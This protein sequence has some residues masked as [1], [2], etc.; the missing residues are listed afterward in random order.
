M[1]PED[2]R[3]LLRQ[4]VFVP[5]RLHL[6][7]GRSFDV[8]HPHLAFV[9]RSTVRIGLPSPLIHIT[10]HVVI[11]ALLHISWIEPIVGNGAL[12]ST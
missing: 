3:Q 5:F 4:R 8:P 7:D 11:V 2:I 6:T 12:A 9:G 1:R 10:D